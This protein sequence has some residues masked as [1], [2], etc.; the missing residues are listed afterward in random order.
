M[1]VNAG[2]HS[3]PSL[4]ESTFCSAP[5]PSLA[6][7][8]LRALKFIS[9]QGIQQWALGRVKVYEEYIRALR[10][11]HNDMV[12][13][14][15]RLPPEILS[16][17]FVSV[18]PDRVGDIRLMHVCHSW[19]AILGR[20]SKFWTDMLAIPILWNNADLVQEALRLSAPR[21]L[22]IRSAPAKMYTIPWMRPHFVRINDLRIAVDQA[23]F[24]QIFPLLRDAYFVTIESLR[25]IWVDWE[26]T[27]SES[28]YDKTFD[29]CPDASLP[30]LKRLSLSAE[31]FDA[32]LVVG[33]IEHLV[34]LAPPDGLIQAPT[35]TTS[36]PN[37]YLRALERCTHG[38]VSLH[39]SISQTWHPFT[40]APIIALPSLCELVIDASKPASIEA[41]LASLDIPP[42]TFVHVRGVSDVPLLRCAIPHHYG[43]AAAEELSLSFTML[44]VDLAASHAG[45]E[46]L[47]VR[48]RASTVDAF[49]SDHFIHL[50]AI[51]T[52]TLS[53]SEQWGLLEPDVPDI[54]ARLPYLT[55]LVIHYPT[56]I[57]AIGRPC[58]RTLLEG[59]A[60]AEGPSAIRALEHLVLRRF[61]LSL[62][63]RLVPILEHC[64]ASAGPGRPL[65][66]LTLGIVPSRTD[67]TSRPTGD[68]RTAEV[69]ARVQRAAKERLG[70]TVDEI[71]VDLM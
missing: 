20:T 64:H 54:L 65:R 23:G 6:K 1:N 67:G 32:R 59:L 38:L 69:V 49:T 62:L 5:A 47:R 30:R 8:D 50:D 52:L 7:E 2:T 22:M 10:I 39:F 13:I 71:I 18:S 16:H 9:P 17:I 3:K 11:L 58:S 46:V 51:R 56:D 42:S 60:S 35:I 4:P 34:V 15:Q 45:K 40:D 19:R 43:V 41:L 63:D 57:G 27:M 31:L 44:T 48:A 12:P 66:S 14:N 29:Q 28:P 21:P 25:L 33:S 55:R 61:D 36:S 68:E 24:R 53:S 26:S 70:A 37:T